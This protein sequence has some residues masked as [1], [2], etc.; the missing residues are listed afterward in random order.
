ML[1]N[2]AGHRWKLRREPLL[3][4]AIDTAAASRERKAA[5]SPS[6]QNGS[7][8]LARKARVRK[9]G[10]D[11]RAARLTMPL[12]SL[13]TRSADLFLAHNTRWIFEPSEIAKCSFIELG[14]L[15]SD[16]GVSQKHTQDAAAWRTIGEVLNDPD[17]VPPIYNVIYGTGGSAD[18]LLEA[19]TLRAGRRR[20]WKLFP[21]LGGLKISPMWVRMLVSPGGVPVTNLQALQVAVDIQV[22]RVTYFL[23]LTNEEPGTTIDED[24]TT[25]VQT[26]WQQN[27][28]DAV[29]P[30][31]C[32]PL[33]GTAGSLDPALWFIGKWGC[34]F[35]EERQERVPIAAFCQGCRLNGTHAMPESERVADRPRERGDMEIGLGRSDTRAGVEGAI[36]LPDVANEHLEVARE[37]DTER[38][39]RAFSAR[40]FKERYL[41]RYPTRAPGSIMPAGYSVP[42]SPSDRHYPKFLREANGGYV[43]TGPPVW[44]G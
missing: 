12:T 17:R 9:L 15:L 33:K 27:I 34:T 6:R 19:V 7:V 10:K 36:R 8:E 41:Q 25:E 42:S 38:H 16:S 28:E 20:K 11:D 44:L 23:G 31:I 5:P 30:A 21:N 37:L 40:E 43:F 18:E 1:D 3:P 22:H 4:C 13:W 32:E 39:G 24:F 14:E 2:N 29:A 26:A 35:C